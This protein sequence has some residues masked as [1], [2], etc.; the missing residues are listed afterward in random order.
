[1]HGFAGILFEMHPHDADA[2]AVLERHGAPGRKRPVVLR[3]LVALRKVRI[4]VVLA[5]EHRD[6]VH[7]TAQ[8]ERRAD[9][10]FDRFSIEDGKRARGAQ[11]HRADL[12]VGRR[13]ERRATAAEDLRGCQ[14]LRMNLEADGG[15]SM[16]ES[17]ECE[18]FQ[19]YHSTL[20]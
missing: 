7:G 9:G 20:H 18:R 17:S 16:F 1:M 3:D 11:T 14:Q 8:R 10:V 12:S 2:A 19:R 15:C 13:T 6:G 5:R 4:E